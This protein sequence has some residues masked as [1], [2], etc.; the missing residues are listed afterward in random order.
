MAAGLLLAAALAVSVLAATAKF[1]QGRLSGPVSLVTQ[2][3]THAT[4]HAE[5]T[6]TFKHLGRVSSSFATQ[7]T[8]DANGR[9]VPVPPSLGTIEVPRGGKLSFTFKW[10]SVEVAPNVFEVTGP[11]TTTGGDGLLSGVTWQGEYRAILDLNN[12]AVVIDGAGMLDR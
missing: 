7:V 6:G 2:D 12:G 5:V 8:L 10:S 4:L 9:P 1:A 11:F 3:D